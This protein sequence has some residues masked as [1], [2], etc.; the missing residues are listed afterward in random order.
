MRIGVYSPYLNT[1]TGG[2]KYILTAASCLSSSHSVVIFWDDPEILIKA[3]KKFGIDLSNVTVEPNIF[4]D[5]IGAVSRFFSTLRFD[6]IF[7]L[8]DGSIPI[9]GAKKL[10]IHF[11][12]PVEWVNSNSFVFLFK[13]SRISKIICNSHFTKKYID[14]KFHAKSFVLYPPATVNKERIFKKTNT[15]L[16]VGRFS[17][18]PNGQD[19]KKLDF[20]IESFK[21]FQKK[22]LKG[23]KLT[24][25]TSVMEEDLEEFREF[26]KKNN[27]KYITIY[28]N[29]PFEK[30]ED[31]YSEAK[32]YWHAAGYG[33]DLE[34]YP[35]RA[36]HFGI[37]TVEA[38]S[39][40]SIP[41]VINAGGQPEIV[42]EGESG[43]LW[44]SQEELIQKTHKVAIDKELYSRL[45][46][47]A[48]EASQNFTT[49]RFCEELDHLIW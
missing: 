48:I 16:T 24:I 34:K 3:T 25:V 30:I 22:R 8:S 38:M 36:E 5:N 32:I 29:I 49:E 11:Q 20:L 9:V 4:K 27:S 15:I 46:Q 26:E 35:E 13:K 1:L 6:R 18:L 12:F 2:E 23:W 19:F 21:L 39:Y 31:L 40:G 14:R 37:A 28:N 42:S 45:S 47:S 33:E 7:F 41:I 43:F 44:N 17:K 10:L